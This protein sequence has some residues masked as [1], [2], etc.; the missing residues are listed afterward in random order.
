MTIS[1]LSAP[2]PVRTSKKRK[3]GP[4][5]AMA[6]TS[7]GVTYKLTLTIPRMAIYLDNYPEGKLSVKQTKQIQPA[8]TLG[9]WKSRPGEGDCRSQAATHKR[10]CCS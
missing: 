2:S 3:D 10:N 8:L 5:Q 1:E 6:S 9:I 7:T 4:V